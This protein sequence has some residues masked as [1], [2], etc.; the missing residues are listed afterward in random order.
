M[1]CNGKLSKYIQEVLIDGFFLMSGCCIWIKSSMVL[2]LLLCFLF[3]FQPN[4]WSNIFK[5][6]LELGQ[7]DLAYNALIAN[8]D[9]VRL[10]IL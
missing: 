7:S 1:Y 9:H 4:L 2:N 10:V 5:H 3:S 8:P 6:H